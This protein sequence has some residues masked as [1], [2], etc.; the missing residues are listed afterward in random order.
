MLSVG[1][2]GDEKWVVSGSKDRAVRFWDAR[3]GAVQLAL[4]GH[5]N[6]GESRGDE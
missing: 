6:S 5:K 1:V 3:T 2:S 4:R